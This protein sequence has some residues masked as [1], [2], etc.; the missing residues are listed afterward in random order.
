MNVNIYA[1][2]RAVVGARTVE[3][4]LSQGS[5]VRSVVVQL[6]ARHPALGPQLVDPAGALLPYIHVFVNGRDA[7]YLHHGVD[8][9]L[10]SQDTIDIFPAV[11]G[12]S[13]Q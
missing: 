7:T 11:A 13:H 12:G 2:L 6:I 9:A 10:G 8:T 5:T 4:A 1:T 3:L